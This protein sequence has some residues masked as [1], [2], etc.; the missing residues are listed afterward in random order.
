[1]I[2][3][4]ICTIALT[5]CGE[6]EHT[7]SYSVKIIAPT[8]TEQGYT[9]HSC[10]CGD[11]YKDK[12]ENALGHD[13]ISHSGQVATCS[14][15][16]W[17]DYIT[18]SRCDYTTY[19]EIDYLPHHIVVDAAVSAS[20]TQTG[21]TEGSHC[22]ECGK[23]ITKQ[24]VT[25]KTSHKESEWVIDENATCSKEGNKHTVCAICG[26][27]VRTQTI[28]KIAHSY[29]NWTVKKPS[30][31]SELGSEQ[32]DC[33]KCDE[34]ETRPIAMLPHT[35]VIDKAVPATCT[36]TGLT[37]GSHCSV[38][39]KE[40]IKQ[41]ATNKIAHDYGD[42]ELTTP[43]TCIE[44]GLEQRKCKN[45]N[46]FETQSTPLAPHTEVIDEAV[47][48]TC[49]ITG[50]TEGKHCSVCNKVLLEQYEIAKIAHTWV[51]DP[52]VEP[53]CTETG[54]TSGS[55]CS[56]CGEILKEQQIIAAER[57][58]KFIDHKIFPTCTETGLT[59]GSHCWRC[60]MVL[61][62]QQIIPATGHDPY[63]AS[64]AIKP[65]CE[66]KGYTAWTWCNN[67]GITLNE[68]Q[69]I[70]A[71][72]HKE[73]ID[74]AIA[75]SCETSGLTEGRHCTVCGY[76]TIPQKTIEA[77]GHNWICSYHD[78]EKHSAHCTICNENVINESHRWRDNDC[79]V[80]TFDAGG[81]KGFNYQLNSTGTGYSFIGSIYGTSYPQ[82]IV[83]PEIYN[84]LPVTE[85]RSHAL[86]GFNTIES[87]TLPFIKTSNSTG[88]GY[89]FGDI[90]GATLSSSETLQFWSEE[91]FING[92]KDYCYCE[93]PSSLKTVIVTKNAIR[94]GAFSNCKYIENIVLGGRVNVVEAY[95]FSGCSNLKN[96]EMQYVVGD[97]SYN[98]YSQSWNYT[99][100]PFGYAFGERQ[101]DKSYVATQVNKSYYIPLSLNTITLTGGEVVLQAFT[102]FGNITNV[103]IEDSVTLLGV[104]AFRDCSALE[105]VE[106]GTGVLS[107][108]NGA[109]ANCTCLSNV[110]ITDIAAWCGIS[111]GDSSTSNPLYYAKNFY[112]NDE[113]IVD[114]IIPESVTEI[115]EGVFQSFNGNSITIT[116][117]VT[118]IGNNAF[119]NCEN[120]TSVIFENTENWK[121]TSG[122]TTHEFTS[123]DISNTSTA[124]TYLIKTYP[125]TWI[126]E[127][128]T[129]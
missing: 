87:L 3:V 117:N 49:S 37:Q 119:L 83:I 116:K 46:A 33:T 84:G 72:G 13:E 53:T 120:V 129:N 101:F 86:A 34:H 90:F 62:P 106:I 79:S 80:C 114:L 103:K 1:M 54:L 74:D 32:R 29:G 51:T 18:C 8:C 99:P 60:N 27:T 105:T 64:E 73:I 128:K 41:I 56:V 71:L 89:M 94:F 12:Y 57:H 123:E 92:T 23:I 122:S 125:R 70:P 112:L 58:V 16:G 68:R 45:C 44:V 24:I 77:L 59:E 121:M 102:G 31:C 98:Q 93:I 78:D 126:K 107:V 10:E 118:K 96:I 35:E 9:L 115:G 65:T 47:P 2:A 39:G 5:A 22:S 97:V 40:I 11:S 21:L 127:N 20:C 88:K 28:D 109:F 104:S 100:Q 17:Q 43:A 38:C 7:H 67:C 55:H 14:R 91:Y 111:F 66:G 30:S 15:K 110:Y 48:A 63:V 124:A 76:V 95:A 36:S 26:E 42:W 25:D 19:Q 50:L 108:G 52:R 82:E 69:E 81:T 85:I 4:C 6:K 113:L 61:E 75:P